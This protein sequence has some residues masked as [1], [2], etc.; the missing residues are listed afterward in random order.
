M[1]QFYFLS[2]LTNALAGALLSAEYFGR[3]V[4][5]FSWLVSHPASRRLKMG[6]GAAVL[7]VG[8]CTLFW[9][10]GGGVAVVGDLIPSITGLVMGVALLFEVFRQDAIFPSETAPARTGLD[11]RAM[12]GIGGLVVALLH[13]FLPERPFL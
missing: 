2:I 6:A 7:L 10:A 3:R 9:P 4:A 1:L 12:I 11:W 5:R 8:A 13:F